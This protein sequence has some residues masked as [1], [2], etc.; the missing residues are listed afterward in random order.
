MWIDVVFRFE[1]LLVFYVLYKWISRLLTG[2]SQLERI[3]IKARRKEYSPNTL[4][5]LGI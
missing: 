1:L 5:L 2:R 4:M 3:L